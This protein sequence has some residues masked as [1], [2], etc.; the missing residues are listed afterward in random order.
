MQQEGS[1]DGS[2]KRY[3][4]DTVASSAKRLRSGEK[5]P[6]S[7]FDKAQRT[8]GRIFGYRRV[9]PVDPTNESMAFM[10]VSGAVMNTDDNSPHIKA[11]LAGKK[12]SPVPS[13]P[14]M[15]PLE[16]IDHRTPSGRQNFFEQVCYLMYTK[17]LFEE[18]AVEKEKA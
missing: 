16:G 8:V 15:I 1:P 2:T 12:K 13:K 7:R 9:A 5:Q 17:G 18:A 11:T 3:L 4:K 10:T 6:E 14:K